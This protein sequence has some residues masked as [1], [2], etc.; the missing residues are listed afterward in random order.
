MDE[1][2]VAAAFPGLEVPEPRWVVWLRAARRDGEPLVPQASGVPGV[3]AAYSLRMA[4]AVAVVGGPVDEAGAEL[5]ARE[6]CSG[7]AWVTGATAEAW[8]LP[9]AGLTGG[10]SCR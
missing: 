1:D 4:R 10:R 3:I 6:L 5:A 2:F 8:P 7:M 9:A